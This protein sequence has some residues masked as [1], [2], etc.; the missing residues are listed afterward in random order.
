MLRTRVKAPRPRHSAKTDTV[1]LAVPE[2]ARPDAVSGAGDPVFVDSS[3]RR[4]RR[5]RRAGYAAAG[6]CAAYTVVLGLSFMGATPFAPRTVLPVPG[7][8]SEEPGTVREPTRQDVPVTSAGPT[9]GTPS[10]SPSDIP[11]VPTTTAFAP[12]AASTPAPTRSP[13]SGGSS[14][15]TGPATSGS[16]SAGSPAASP[17]PSASTSGPSPEGSQSP[18]TAPAGD[19]S[20]AVSPGP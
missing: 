17:T 19:S 1:P 15:A 12:G 3:G 9:Y 6:L 13:T 20:S 14:G 2:H 8:P 16:P 18:T 10:V 7:V 5:L 4:A 11:A